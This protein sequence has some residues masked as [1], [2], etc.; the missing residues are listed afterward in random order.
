MKPF[1]WTFIA[2]SA[3]TNQY[4]TNTGKEEETPAASNGSRMVYGRGIHYSVFLPVPGT[5]HRLATAARCDD[6]RSRA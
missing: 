5:N 4:A 3:Q 6:I 2:E 1:R